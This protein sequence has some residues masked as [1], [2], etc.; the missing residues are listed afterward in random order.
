MIAARKAD[1]DLVDLLLDRYHVD[2]DSLSVGGET[3]RSIA[4]DYAKLPRVSD[5]MKRGYAKIEA[6]LAA[7]G[8]ALPPSVPADEV[9]CTGANHEPFGAEKIQKILDQCPKVT[10]LDDLVPLMPASV[11]SNYVLSYKT[12]GIQQGSFTSP[13][14]ITLGDDLKTIMS[15]TGDPTLSGYSNLEM[16][17]FKD[18]TPE[19]PAHFEFREVA[20]DQ[21]KP[22]I[23]EKNP[24]QCMH[25]HGES[26]P[27]P[28]WDSW[29]L[30]P[31]MYESEQAAKYP[32]ERAHYV[33][34]L[35][36]SHQGRYQYL[37][38][39]SDQPM[40]IRLG[41]WDYA[42]TQKTIRADTIVE[43]MNSEVIADELAR[44]PKLQPYKYAILGALSCT[45]PIE[46]Y[47]P[48]VVNA[49]MPRKFADI[50]KETQALD[51]EEFGAR[52]DR[53][54]EILPG[55]PEGSY[56]I[57]FQNGIF[58]TGQSYNNDVISRLRYFVEGQGIPMHWSPSFN[59]IDDGKVRESYVLFG[60]W[61]VEVKAWSRLL[62][63]SD[64]S[65]REV[66][67]LYA[68][69]YANLPMNVQSIIGMFRG[70]DYQPQLP[71]I[72]NSKV[73]GKLNELSLQ[74]LTA[75]FRPESGSQP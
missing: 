35:K 50:L 10:T 59:L 74:R 65:E 71:G 26:R 13:R 1:A 24:D 7:M 41:L 28:R 25:C 47:L 18:S 23:S 3:A 39:P 57:G 15:F 8:A 56:A 75:A 69:R 27:I 17:E 19:E 54:K 12:R 31:G 68:E 29:Y 6:K 16:I 58:K 52:I 22:F 5:K 4:R 38:P 66:K 40:S 36:N 63:D 73:C 72:D 55:A 51:L 64:P 21:G 44:N 60:F 9:N 67:Q 49:K 53:Q 14:V 43:D 48:D 32:L 45:D 30:W 61:Q 11:R 46:G 20:F 62:S 42:N 34:Y 2:T 37:L 70:P 33:E